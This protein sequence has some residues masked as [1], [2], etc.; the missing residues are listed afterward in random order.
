MINH[1]PET[2]STDY[3]ECDALYFEELSLETV[4]DIYRKERPTGI[5]LSMGGQIPNNLAMQLDR[6][7]VRILGT[8]ASAVDNAEDR[9]KFSKLLDSLGI[10]QPEWGELVGMKEALAFANQVRY[11]VLPFNSDLLF[12]I[13]FSLLF[14]GKS[15]TY[16]SNCFTPFSM[17]NNN[18]SSF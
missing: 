7:G 2:V 12:F 13:N 18:Y 1:N 16:N 3:N 6:A 5:I 10:K 8:P 9:H 4:L 11:P 14:C 17:G 15:S